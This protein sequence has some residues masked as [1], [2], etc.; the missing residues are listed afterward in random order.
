MFG[1]WVD[2]EID[3][4]Q[5]EFLDGETRMKKDRMSAAIFHRLT[6]ILDWTPGSDSNSNSMRK[7]APGSQAIFEDDSKGRYQDP[8]VVFAKV[9]AR[10]EAERLA[11]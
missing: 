8:A 5:D 1:T 9:K 4:V 11:K 10:R 6:T 7:E 2:A 3:K